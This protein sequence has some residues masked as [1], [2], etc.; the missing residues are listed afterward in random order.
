MGVVLQW[1]D[2]LWVTIMNVHYYYRLNIC[3]LRVHLVPESIYTPSRESLGGLKLSP[4][5][6]C[7]EIQVLVHTFL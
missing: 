2:G 1:F 3:T 4:F 6:I 7:L 5:P